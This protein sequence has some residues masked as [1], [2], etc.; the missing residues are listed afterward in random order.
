MVEKFA[1]QKYKYS[2]EA[3]FEHGFFEIYSKHLKTQK[4]SRITNLN[5]LL[6]EFNKDSKAK[7]YAESTW[8]IPNKKELRRLWQ[9]AG[10]EFL[11]SSFI[12]YLEKALDEDREIGGWNSYHDF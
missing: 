2:I 11:D 3:N 4:V 8:N 5:F 6:S 1:G 12:F 9:N 10:N 7:N